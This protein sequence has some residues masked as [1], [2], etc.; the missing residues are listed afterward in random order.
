[1]ALQTW[2][3]QE[4]RER[5]AGRGELWLGLAAGLFSAAAWAMTLW[6]V[7]TVLRGL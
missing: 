5:P 7:I 3:E 4:E 1:M 2:S 6:S